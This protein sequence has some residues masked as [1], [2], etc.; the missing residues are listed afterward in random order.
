MNTR[1]DPKIVTRN[2]QDSVTK[3][4]VRIKNGIGTFDITEDFRGWISLGEGVQ[5]RFVRINPNVGIHCVPVMKLVAEALGK[6]YRIGQYATLSFPLGST[7]PDMQEF[8]FISA[9]DL[10]PEANRLAD[11]INQYGIPFTRKIACYEE[12]IPRL[13]KYIPSRGGFPESYAAALCVSG[14]TQAAYAFIDEQIANYIDNGD[15]KEANKYRQL[16]SYF[17]THQSFG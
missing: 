2:C 13:Q 14:N 15:Q 17:E 1:P 3:F 5:P 8:L 6:K 16:K 4:G 11:A 7:C 12:L 10:V 9:D